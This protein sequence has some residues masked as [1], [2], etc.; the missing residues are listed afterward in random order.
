MIVFI[1]KGFLSFE[2]FVT[3]LTGLIISPFIKLVFH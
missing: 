3:I 1:T 2:L